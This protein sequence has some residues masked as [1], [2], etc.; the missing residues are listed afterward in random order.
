MAEIAE[1][2]RSAARAWAGAGYALSI[3]T[4]QK[5]MQMV[6]RQAQGSQGRV[7]YFLATAAVSLLRSPA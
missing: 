3:F 1:R 6:L 4:D 2:P 5:M 7:G